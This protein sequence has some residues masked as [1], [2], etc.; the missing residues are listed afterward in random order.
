[1]SE[2]SRHTTRKTKQHSMGKIRLPFKIT[3]WTALIAVLALIF[4][5]GVSALAIQN[6]HKGSSILPSG[7]TSSTTQ[8]HTGKPLNTTS[9]PTQPTNTT[10]PGKTQQKP[11]STPVAM[12]D[13]YGCIPNAPGYD[14]CEKYSKQ[15]ANPSSEPYTPAT[16]TPTC[17]TELQTSYQQTY[18]S[19]Y[20][21]LIRQEASD[22]QSLKSQLPPGSAQDDAV[23]M[24]AQQYAP[25]FTALKSQLNSE[26]I[27]INCPTI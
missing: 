27:S 18:D 14:D 23:N 16:S 6:A 25:K 22:V 13:Q 20:M 15:N 21:T 2:Q 8:T 3:R 4:C 19:Q 1:M 7:T 17:N 5:A 10:Q 26:L 24:V 9:E 11:T 12:P